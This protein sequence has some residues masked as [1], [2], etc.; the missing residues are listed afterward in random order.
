VVSICEDWNKKGL[1][2]K[3]IDNEEDKRFLKCVKWVLK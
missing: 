1:A 3:D 2:P